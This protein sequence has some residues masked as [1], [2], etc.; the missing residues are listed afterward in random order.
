MDKIHLIKNFFDKS[1]CDFYIDYINN[2]TDKFYYAPHAMRW[3]L[4]VGRDNIPNHGRVEDFSPIEDISEVVRPLFKRIEDTAKAI[5]DHKGDLYICNIFLA[6]QG[7]GAIIPPHHDTDFG[8]NSQLKY[9]GVIYLNTMSKPGDGELYFSNLDYAVKPKAGDLVLFPSH[10]EYTHEVKSITE[11][12]YALPV[13]LT[14]EIEYR[15]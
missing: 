9:S 1:S 5:Y 11:D 12:R 14:E 13:F 10:E 15:L 3:Q 8:M 7:P 2:N 4:T 6:K